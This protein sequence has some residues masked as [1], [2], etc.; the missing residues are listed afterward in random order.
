MVN[1]HNRL[2]NNLRTLA[3]LPW[4]RFTGLQ[5]PHFPNAYKKS[6]F[7]RFW[8]KEGS[9]LEKTCVPRFR[10]I[11]NVIIFVP[12]IGSWFSGTFVP[13]NVLKGFPGIFLLEDSNVE[14]IS[15]FIRKQHK[16]IIL[17]EP[18][19]NYIDF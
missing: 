16:A 3:I 17:S 8:E 15:Q 4:N 9:I 13:V 12:F 2:M 11:H 1:F 18:T 5:N 10:E 7:R 14:A 19:G 6:V